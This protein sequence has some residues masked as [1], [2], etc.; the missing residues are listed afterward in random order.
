[1]KVSFLIHSFENGGA[2]NTLIKLANMFQVKGHDVSIFVMSSAGPL[3]SRINE[4][5]NIV[6]LKSPRARSALFPLVSAMRKLRS[7]WIITSLLTPSILSLVLKI[8]M[9]GNVHIMIR[10]AS[11]PSFDKP[12]SIKSL[13]LHYIVVMLYRFADRVVAVSN[14][15][16]MDFSEYYFF[17]IKKVNVVYNPVIF[18]NI[19]II[20]AQR[21]SYIGPLRLLF[22]GR[23]VRIKRIELQ[24]EALS[25]SKKQVDGIH[26]T[27]CGNYP[28]PVYKEELLRLARNLG[29]QES[30]TWLGFQENIYEQLNNSDCLLLTSDVE[31]LPSVLIE[32]LSVGVR[33]IARDCPHGP[34]EILDNGRIGRL[35]PYSD[36]SA[37]MLASLIVDEAMNPTS[38]NYFDSHIQKFTGN[39]IYE[40]YRRLME[41]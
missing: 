23:V 37:E 9:F 21:Q 36:C 31:G 20:R 26:L 8:L 30:I 5:V 19:N 35:I 6:D 10:E 4:G 2:Q 33:V 18:N 38:V 32:A 15:V 1:M 24:I 3:V 28:D 25:I 17:P 40:E 13:V 22:V 11:T 14:G 7:E 39:K 27:I 12:M 16:K 34:R 29:I 41:R